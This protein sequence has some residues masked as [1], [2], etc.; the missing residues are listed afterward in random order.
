MK[1][2]YPIVII[3][4]EDRVKYYETLDKAH[5]TG[6]YDDFIKLVAKSLNESLNLYLNMID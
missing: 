2:N 5:I 1:D 6:N 3:K 4:N